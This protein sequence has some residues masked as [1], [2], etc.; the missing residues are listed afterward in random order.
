MRTTL[1]IP[2][3]LYRQVRSRSA[4]EGLT[5][6]SVTITLYSDWLAGSGWRQGPTPRESAKNAALPPWAGLCASAVTRNADGPHDMA[7]IRKS[8]SSAKR[9]SLP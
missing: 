3:A 1:D 2:D 9:I 8:V 7:S 4:L 5:L 6:R